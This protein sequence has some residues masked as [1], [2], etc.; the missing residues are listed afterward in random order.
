MADDQGEQDPAARPDPAPTPAPAPSGGRFRRAV[1]SPTVRLG[2]LAAVAVV[3]AVGWYGWTQVSP[4]IEAAHDDDVA[5]TVPDAPRLVA[6]AGE[7]VYRIDPTRSSVTYEVDEKIVGQSSG[8]ARGST[9]GI[10]GDVAVN[11]TD[12][13]AT[14]VGEI[15]VDVEQLHSDNNLRDARIR[16][17]YLESHEFPLARLTVDSLS[18]M[19]ATIEAGR[20]YSFTMDGELAAHDRVVPVSWAVDATVDDTQLVATAHTVVRLSDLDAGPISLAGL[21]STGDDV[22]LTM[23]LVALDPSQN[24]VPD[25]IAGPDAGG[26]SGPSPS[27]AA[28]VQPILAAHCASCHARGQVGAAHWVLDTAGDAAAVSDGIETV[29]ASGYM[30]PWPASDVGVPLAHSRKLSPDEVDTLVAWSRAG[31]DLDVPEDTAVEATANPDAAVVRH[32]VTLTMPEAYTGSLDTPN[33]YRCFVL[34]PGFTEAT[35][36]TGYEVTPGTRE[37]IHHAQIF[38]V[39]SLGATEGHDRSGADGQPGWTCFGGPGGTITRTETPGAAARRAG[40]TGQGGLIAGWVPGQDPSLYPENSGILFEPGDALVLQIH[41]HYEDVVPVP[42]QSTVALQTAPGTDPISP[43]AIVNPVA[44]VEIPC[45]AGDPAP[46]CDRDAALA[47]N[48]RLYGPSGAFTEAGLLLLCRQTPASLT[49][50]FVG[51]ASSTCDYRVPVTGRLVSAMGHMHTL[52]QSFRLT[53]DPDTDAAQVVLDIPEWNFDWQMNYSLQTP[54]RVDAGQ[55]IRMTC[56]WDR[57]IDPN[58]PSKYIVFAD[59]T[60]DEMCF[61]TYAVIPDP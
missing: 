40:F 44:P 49:M 56:T 11:A 60:E 1:R 24:R 2:T 8:T 32:D 54:I 48:V 51:V 7:T 41:Y 37:E 36:L 23:E 19:P 42:D 13:A 43:I 58:R 25:E 47:E 28:E 50:G 46:L 29:V 31:G 14:R 17:D 10:A 3:A 21:V 4:L 22:G 6:T 35:Y 27:F 5:Y 45:L 18:D 59:G 15:V 39:D 52:G 33:D 55:T 12:P 26:G 16:H 53:L 61:S 20:S 57:S 34:D 9:N 38:Q 30:P